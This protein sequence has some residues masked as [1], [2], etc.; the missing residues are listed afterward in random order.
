MKRFRYSNQKT[1][2][3]TVWF[4]LI[5]QGVIALLP[6]NQTLLTDTPF[7]ETFEEI[8]DELP[9]GFDF[10]EFDDNT[11]LLN[12]GHIINK[13]KTVITNNVFV[14]VITRFPNKIP[15]PPPEV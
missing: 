14:R 13:N 1:I 8:I 9:T 6:A 15:I 10:F 7:Y 5:L 4:V 11:P 3:L 12:S 2:L